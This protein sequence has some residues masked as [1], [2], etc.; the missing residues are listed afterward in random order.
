M[1]IILTITLYLIPFF[2]FSQTKYVKLNLERDTFYI[3]F[4]Y[5]NNSATKRTLNDSVFY[6]YKRITDESFSINEFVNKKKTWT[7]KFQAI[8]VN[9]SLV[10]R[11]RMSRKPIKIKKVK[12]YI[13]NPIKIGTN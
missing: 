6:M 4:F 9:D 13:G 7:K 3:T 11:E 1:K 2:T 8:P 5:K 10:V 12:Y